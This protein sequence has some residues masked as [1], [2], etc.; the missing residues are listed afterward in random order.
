MIQE[1]SF[2]ILQLQVLIQAIIYFL[3][4]SQFGFG[5][6][7]SR[8]FTMTAHFSF[9]FIKVEVIVISIF[10]MVLALIN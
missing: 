6:R 10:C 2:T 8:F 3:I 5:S 7:V 4:S 1:F 9:V